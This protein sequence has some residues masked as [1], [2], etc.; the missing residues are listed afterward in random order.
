MMITKKIK[1]PISIRFV[2][3]AQCLL[4][5]CFG[6]YRVQKQKTELLSINSNI[7]VN[8]RGK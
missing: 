8:T 2:S 6:C 7:S 3:S 5:F 4:N 1:Y